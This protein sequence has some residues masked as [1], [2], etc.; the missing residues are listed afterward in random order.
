MSSY[1]IPEELTYESLS[2]L[3]PSVKS[4]YRKNPFNGASF[5]SGDIQLK[6]NKIY[7]FYEE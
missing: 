3:Y 1:G 4:E 7:I 5:A 2:R 6:I